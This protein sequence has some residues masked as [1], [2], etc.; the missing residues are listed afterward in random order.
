MAQKLR[1][2][3]SLLSRPLREERYRRGINYRNRHKIKDFSQLQTS[4][5]KEGTFWYLTVTTVKTFSNIC[6]NSPFLYLIFS[7]WPWS[8]VHFSL[9]LS[10]IDVSNF[11]EA[12]KIF[13]HQKLTLQSNSDIQKKTSWNMEEKG[14]I[15]F[16]SC[17][18]LRLTDVDSFSILFSCVP[19]VFNQAFLMQISFLNLCVMLKKSFLLCA[20]N[21]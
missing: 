10:F 3:A 13:F 5:L 21:C 20:R 14:S 9:F 2:K 18:P 4:V 16:C 15:F 12:R 1:E 6:L 7:K 19:G 8:F 11:K 17:H